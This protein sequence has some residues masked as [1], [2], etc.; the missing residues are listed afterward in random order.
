M[1]RRLR[2][3]AAARCGKRQRGGGHWEPCSA[4][5]AAETPVPARSG[6]RG[7]AVDRWQHSANHGS[8]S[9]DIAVTRVLGS[10]GLVQRPRPL[11]GGGHRPP[12]KRPQCHSIPGN[13]WLGAARARRGCRTRTGHGTRARCAEAAGGDD[14]DLRQRL[15]TRRRGAVPGLAE[16]RHR[17]R[18]PVLRIDRSA[19]QYA[20]SVRSS[21]GRICCT[22][23]GCAAKDVESMHASNCA[24]PTTCASP[25]GWR[26]SPNAP[27]AS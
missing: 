23:S 27:A 26:R 18:G 19:E 22:A 9:M 5:Y 17:R 1:A 21:L 7:S 4:V 3:G 2:G 14:A 25:S 13:P 20:D 24:L 6:S 10:L 11:R 16:R 12:S 8:R 15:R